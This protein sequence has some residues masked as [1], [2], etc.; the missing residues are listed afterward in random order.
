MELLPHRVEKV[1][2]PQESAAGSIVGQP[3][4]IHAIGEDGAPSPEFFYLE[5]AADFGRQIVSDRTVPSLKFEHDGLP[6]G[7]AASSVP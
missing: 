2:W 6:I 3:F 7:E 4:N 1:I 5:L